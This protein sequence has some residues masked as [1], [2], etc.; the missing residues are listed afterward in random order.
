MPTFVL[1]GH[2]GPDSYLMKSAVSR[3]VPGATITSVDDQ[4]GLKRHVHADAVLLIN[5]VLEYGFDT[6]CG[7][8]LIRTL[9]QSE[10]R[11]AMML[12][13]NLP[14]AQSQAQ[15]AGARPGFG[16][17]EINSD[18]TKALLREAAGLNGA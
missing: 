10:P 8:E 18:R 3:A 16:K 17:R 2:C 1:I 6:D 14:E 15:A 13:S 12:V 9:A 5:R 7:I 4:A 11:P